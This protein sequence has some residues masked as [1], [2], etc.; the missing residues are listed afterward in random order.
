MTI[1]ESNSQLYPKPITYQTKIDYWLLLYTHNRYNLLFY[2]LVGILEISWN[3]MQQIIK[4]LQWRLSIY[5][6]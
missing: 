6:P 3:T 1:L 4:K 2:K 5:L